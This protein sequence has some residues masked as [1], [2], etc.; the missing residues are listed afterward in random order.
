M[1]H[2]TENTVAQPV[3]I[4]FIKNPIAG[5]TKTRLAKTLGNEEALRIY[6]LLL[7]HTRKQSQALEAKRMLYYSEFINE[8]DDWSDTSFDKYIQWGKSLG[9]RM[10]NAFDQAFSLG[11]KAIIIGSDCAELSTKILQDALDALDKH[12]FVIGPAI[13]GGYYLIGMSS[14]QPEVF[15]NIE[16]ST[17]AVLSSTL[18]R[19]NDLGASHFL[20]PS[21]SDVDTEEDW[22]AV[23][24]KINF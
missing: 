24:S 8:E 10:A 14:Y 12:D 9:E 21:L 6:G 7:Q 2:E 17:D 19:I 15:E 18:K 13:D 1:Q 3:L 5:K 22:N 11:Q 23:G 20:L 4:I 16:W